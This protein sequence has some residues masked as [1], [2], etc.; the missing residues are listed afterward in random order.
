MMTDESHAEGRQM[1]GIA[2]Q[3][4]GIAGIRIDYLGAKAKPPRP[5]HGQ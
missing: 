5:G 2:E 3:V 1:I 4:I